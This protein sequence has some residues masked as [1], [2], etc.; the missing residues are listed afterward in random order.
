[1]K[2]DTDSLAG[3]KRSAVD[4]M[5]PQVLNQRSSVYNSS[6]NTILKQIFHIISIRTLTKAEKN[7]IVLIEKECLTIV[8]GS[9]QFR[10]Y[11]SGRPFRVETDHKW[12]NAQ[13]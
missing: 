6:L 7:I 13:K 9:K 11:S 5:I 2:L 4:V 10:H 3:N 8:Y 12:L 1:M